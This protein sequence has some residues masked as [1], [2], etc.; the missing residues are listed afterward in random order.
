MSPKTITEPIAQ[1][2]KVK[3]NPV[4]NVLLALGNLYEQSGK[5]DAALGVYNNILKRNPKCASALVARAT[6]YLLQ[7]QDERAFK[8]LHKAIGI[9]PKD[10][11]I[12]R[13]RALAYMIDGNFDAALKDLQKSLDSNE[14]D[15]VSVYFMYAL[16]VKQSSLEEAN[17]FLAN[18]V[19]NKIKN[20]DW[21][22]PVLQFL[23]GNLPMT[24]LMDLAFSKPKQLETRAFCGFWRVFSPY[25]QESKA[26]LVYVKDAGSG[27]SFVR[28]LA[29]RGL[30]LVD[31]GFKEKASQ[32]LERADRIADMDWM[33]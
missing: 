12:L 11:I 28:A 29:V 2:N 19:D 17:A 20:K 16:K 22:Y 32:A 18:A 21:P 30:R 25:P 1:K 4:D 23:R 3:E 7:S 27:N 14:W 24:T 9:G 8:D 5:I 15:C 6:I 33:N 13:T 10:R 31:E 26:D